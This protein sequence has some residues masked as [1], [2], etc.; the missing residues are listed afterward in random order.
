MLFN[1]YSCLS[2]CDTQDSLKL[3]SG[4]EAF[5]PRSKDITGPFPPGHAY[6]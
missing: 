2:V 6:R 1:K 4:Q 5:V 3:G